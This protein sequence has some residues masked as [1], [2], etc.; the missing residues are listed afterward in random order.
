[1]QLTTKH[2]RLNYHNKGFALIV[3]MLV[4]VLLMMIAFAL[5]SLSSVTSK[6]TSLGEAIEEARANARLG[7]M[8]AIGELQ[9]SMGPDRRISARALTLS[10]D[11][12]INTSLDSSNPRSWWV[13]IAGTDSTYGLDAESSVSTSNP[14]AVWLVSGLDSS[15]TASSQLTQAFNKPVEMYGENTIDLSMTGGQALT[16]GIIEIDSNKENRIGGYGRKWP[17]PSSAG[18]LSH[19]PLELVPEPPRC[20]GGQSRSESE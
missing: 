14:A 7:L 19:V 11:G 16:A 9:Q 4:M 6:S 10:Q 8:V 3:T 15:A 2:L 1:M 17:S 18:F 5:L 12:R 13:G 20:W